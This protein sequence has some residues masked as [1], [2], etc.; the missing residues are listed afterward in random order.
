MRHFAYPHGDVTA[1][2][3]REF[4]TAREIGFNSAVTTRPGLVD[5]HHADQLTALP[6]VSLNGCFQSLRQLDVLISGVPF[7]IKDALKRGHATA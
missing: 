1:A 3:E 5:N 2:G 4:E 6:R 7:M